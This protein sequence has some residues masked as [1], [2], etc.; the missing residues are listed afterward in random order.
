M[1]RFVDTNVF[2]YVLTK[3]PGFFEVSKRI[4]GRIEDGEEAVTSTVVVDEVCVFLEM[5]GRSR[6]IPVALSSIRSYV[7]MEVVSFALEDMAKASKLVEQYGIDWHDCLNV[8]LMKKRGVEE[9]YSNDRHFDKVEGIK[10][11]FT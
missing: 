3:D 8:V 9:V 5:H 2:I 4:L 7:S 6:E 1:R 11:I 10:R